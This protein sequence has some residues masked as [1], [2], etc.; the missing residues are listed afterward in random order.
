V[1]VTQRVLPY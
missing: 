1:F